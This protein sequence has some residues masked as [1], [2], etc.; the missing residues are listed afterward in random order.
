MLL[1]FLREN[2]YLKDGCSLL[3]KKNRQSQ[4][5]EAEIIKHFLTLTY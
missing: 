5:G 2:K 3:I 4:T 1:T